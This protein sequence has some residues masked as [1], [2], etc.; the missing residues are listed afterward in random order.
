VDLEGHPPYI[1]HIVETTLASPDRRQAEVPDPPAADARDP[2]RPGAC[3]RARD[4]AEA[5]QILF[6]WQVRATGST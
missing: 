3:Q 6:D 5:H 4:G 2:A 1:Q